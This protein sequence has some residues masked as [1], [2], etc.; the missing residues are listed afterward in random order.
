MR[1]RDPFIPVLFLTASDDEDI[2]ADALTLPG[3]GKREFVR[4][5]CGRE[6]FQIRVQEMVGKNRFRFGPHAMIDISMHTATI[7]GR[8]TPRHLQP[9]VCN[10]AVVFER[11]ENITLSRAELIRQWGGSEGSLD[12]TVRVLR[13]AVNDG[14]L[15]VIQNIHGTG[16][17]YNPQGG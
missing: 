16:Y 3:R 10:L 11:N 1:Q 15:T 17:V 13:R 6:A 9:Q 4:K 7:D 5:P 14:R 8:K 12:E 2:E